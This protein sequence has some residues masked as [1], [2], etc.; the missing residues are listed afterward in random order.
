[1]VVRALVAALG[2][3]LVAV[4]LVDWNSLVWL[5]GPQGT[6]DAQTRGDPVFVQAQAS[7][8]VTEVAVNDYDAVRRGQLLYRIEDDTY[9]AEVDRA[10]AQVAEA[11]AQVHETEARIG[12][13][14]ATVDT[15]TKN[16]DATAAT[17]GF[18]REDQARFNA[19]AGTPGDLLRERQR[20]NTAAQTQAA[21]LDA[22]RSTIGANVAQVRTLRAQLVQQQALL[23]S[24]RHALDLARISLGW[25]R[26]VAPADGVVTERLVRPGQLVGP[27]RRLIS[28]VPLPDV[29]VVAWYREEQVADMRVGQAVDIHVDAYPDHVFAGRIDSF[30]PTSQ[31]WTQVFPPDRATGNYT[32]VVQRVPVKITFVAPVP[33][34]ARLIPGLSVETSVRTG[35]TPALQSAPAPSRPPTV[36]PASPLASR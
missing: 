7:G 20:A 36:S 15:A 3:G 27:G 17:L 26:V 12:V 14:D 34:F 33:Q 16:A 30:E 13:Q 2:L 28:F 32:K 8:Y 10:A 21:T 23:D 19:L 24:R 9:R 11:V 35:S 29:W 1:M 22:D 25:T 18:A 5:G 31:A 4:M 6:N